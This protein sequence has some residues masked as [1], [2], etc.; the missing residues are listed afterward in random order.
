MTQVINSTL[1]RP[2]RG[3]IV[4]LHLQ[5]ADYLL[6]GLPIVFAGLVLVVYPLATYHPNDFFGF[7][8]SINAI[9][10]MIFLAFG[11]GYLTAGLI[12]AVVTHRN[13]IFRLWMVGI[14]LAVMAVPAT[15]LGYL[16]FH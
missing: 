12:L 10:F 4:L 11:G 2:E 13:R 1:P 3:K 16:Y 15:F 7:G 5:L 9:L 14:L 8:G 6:V